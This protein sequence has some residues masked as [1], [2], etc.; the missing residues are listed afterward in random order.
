MAKYY[1]IKV[2][3]ID[4]ET[5]EE[6]VLPHSEEEK[7][8]GFCIM[9]DQGNSVD[10]WIHH[11]TIYGIAQAIGEDEHF[12]TA[13]EMAAIARQRRRESERKR[14]SGFE[15]ML[16]SLIGGGDNGSDS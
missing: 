4:T 5:G 12:G 3:E 9:G 14:A 10:G 13:A 2:T 11:M 6:T 7:Y 15:S 8:N 1:T 16:A